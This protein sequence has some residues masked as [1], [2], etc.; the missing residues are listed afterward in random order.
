LNYF[1]ASETW[2]QKRVDQDPSDLVAQCNLSIDKQKIG[3]VYL[4]QGEGESALKVFRQLLDI[5]KLMADQDPVVL[6]AQRDLNT[7]HQRFADAQVQLGSVDEV[8][9]VYNTALEI[10]QKLFDRNPQDQSVQQ[11]P[12]M[13]FSKAASLMRDMGMAPDFVAFIILSPSL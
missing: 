11:N 1:Q 2:S 8:L 13:T 10:S 5:R 9:V 7:S 6:Q 3:D 12:A 4:R